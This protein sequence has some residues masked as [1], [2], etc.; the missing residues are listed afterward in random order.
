[1]RYKLVRK[2]DGL[3]KESKEVCWLSF[4]EDGFFKARH[5]SPKIGRCLLM[6]PFNRSF[7]WQT[8]EITAILKKTKDYVKFKTKNSEYTLFYPKV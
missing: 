8:T 5:P 4:K 6:S 2:G 1:M 7:T 3:T